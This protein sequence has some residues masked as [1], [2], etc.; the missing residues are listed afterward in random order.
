MSMHVPE[1]LCWDALGRLREVL[2]LRKGRRLYCQG[3]ACYDHVALMQIAALEIRITEYSVLLKH[4][5]AVVSINDF[6][7]RATSASV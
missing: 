6:L 4:A 1:H 5:F 7:F 2:N 3:I